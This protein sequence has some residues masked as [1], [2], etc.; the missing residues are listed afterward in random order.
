MPIPD[1]MPLLTNVRAVLVDDDP[2]T[3]EVL[4]TVLGSSGAD[5]I[6]A[7]SAAQG[8]A[9]IEQRAPDVIIADIGMPG[10]DG[11]SFIQKAR[12]I[13]AA[14]GVH[15][16]AIALTAYARLE[17]RERTLAAGF[18]RHIAKPADPRIVVLAVTE[19]V[20]PSA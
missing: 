14:R 8:L 7:E 17:D 13:L 5:V 15:P 9:A 3:R 1:E 2:D 4:Q 10:E 18:Q 12:G 20:G 19:L 6:A 16:P 11:Y